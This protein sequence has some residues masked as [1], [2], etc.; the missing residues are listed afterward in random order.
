MH[1]AQRNYNSFQVHPVG[2]AVCDRPAPD[3]HALRAHLWFW[4]LTHRQPGLLPGPGQLQCAH[5]Q[6]SVRVNPQ[7]FSF[8]LHTPQ[9]LPTSPSQVTALWCNPPVQCLLYTCVLA[10][11]RFTKTV[12]GRCSSFGDW[13]SGLVLHR[14]NLWEGFSKLFKGDSIVIWWSQ[15]IYSTALDI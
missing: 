6:A 2:S 4:A 14:Y 12:S 7:P 1:C 13:L 8:A 11:A 5:C 9:I 15:I 10:R 3:P